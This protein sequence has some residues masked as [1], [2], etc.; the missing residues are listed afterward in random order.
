MDFVCPHSLL[1]GFFCLF[2]CI[3]KRYANFALHLFQINRIKA[4][5][6]TF[7]YAKVQNNLLHKNGVPHIMWSVLGV[8]LFFCSVEI[9]RESQ[10]EP[11][12]F[13]IDAL[14]KKKQ[15]CTKNLPYLI[16]C[17]YNLKLYQKQFDVPKIKTTWKWTMLGFMLWSKVS[18][19]KVLADTVYIDS[20]YYTL[21]VMLIVTQEN[22]KW[23]DPSAEKM[24]IYIPQRNVLFTLTLSGFSVHLKSYWLINIR[25]FYFTLHQA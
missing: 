14:W 4:T 23:T 13:P 2:V 25:S 22:V 1:D 9:S 3:R 7:C 11:V 18:I 16:K 19:I 24:N 6:Q 8:C 17:M 12:S 10:I 15:F 21:T 20:R 5:N